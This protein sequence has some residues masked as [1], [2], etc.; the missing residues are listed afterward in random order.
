MFLGCF[1]EFVNGLSGCVRRRRPIMEFRQK[2]RIVVFDYWNVFV[3]TSYAPLLTN[4]C[5]EF[6]S[7]TG[8][9]FAEIRDNFLPFRS[10]PGV[11]S[12][13]SK[14]R[15]SQCRVLAAALAL[16]P[17]VSA[18]GGG[19]LTRHLWR[20]RSRC[21][22]TGK[23][24]FITDLR[25]DATGCR[26]SLSPLAVARSSIMS[27]QIW[28]CTLFCLP[29]VYR[30]SGDS[31]W[32]VVCRSIVSSLMAPRFSWCLAS[33][34]HSLRVGSTRPRSV[35]LFCWEVLSYFDDFGFDLVSASFYLPRR[36]SVFVQTFVIFIGIFVYLPIFC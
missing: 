10:C 14:Y 23:I 29:T 19:P 13:L 1:V 36:F 32:F 20:N 2:F 28:E 18:P 12:P 25:R 30:L 15:W 31:R 16:W 8:G 7:G 17:C 4:R 35:F 27:L 22:E 11:A 24:L 6:L 21:C 26:A 5:C 3:G 9:G 33:A 34:C